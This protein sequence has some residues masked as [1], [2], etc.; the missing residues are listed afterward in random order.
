MSLSCL[1]LINSELEE[2]ESIE[3][4]RETFPWPSV[5]SHLQE[6][7]MQRRLCDVEH[8]RAVHTAVVI[9]LLDDETVREG[10][11][12]QHVEQ[13]GLAGT[14]LV[15]GLNQIDVTLG[16][17]NTFGYPMMFSFSVNQLNVL[18]SVTLQLVQSKAI[19]TTKI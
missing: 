12:V 13:R 19:S 15:A 2:G 8:L 6:P 9:H 16:E 1:F 11:D 4:C 3:L 18:L 10:R 17:E 7:G 14:N 5:A